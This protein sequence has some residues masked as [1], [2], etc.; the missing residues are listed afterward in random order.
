[1][2]MKTYDNFLLVVFGVP[3][4]FTIRL[5]SIMEFYVLTS[6]STSLIATT[7]RGH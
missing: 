7:I 3:L 4:L 2:K 5:V 1:M 6:F